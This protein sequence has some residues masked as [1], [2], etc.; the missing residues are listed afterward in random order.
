MKPNDLL[1]DIMT[2]C[3]QMGTSGINT[4]PT[5]DNYKAKIPF[6][7][8]EVQLELLADCKPKIEYKTTL[9]RFTDFGF[10]AL[11]VPSFNEI[12][13]IIDKDG[14]NCFDNSDFAY[15]E[16]G[17]LYVTNDYYGSLS[18]FYLPNS[19]ITALDDDFVL[20]ES[21]KNAIVYYCIAMLLFDQNTSKAGFFQ[22]KYEDQSRKLK[23]KDA[24]A[25]KKI[26]NV[27][28]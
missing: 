16:N 1:N 20:N 28:A 2:H 3:G 27:Y 5:V 24:N 10:R 11:S 19:T 14:R 4:N 6:L 8:N 25:I 22:Q 9:T 23:V 18:V 26:R 17:V 13:S 15:I 7:C 12:T 21:F